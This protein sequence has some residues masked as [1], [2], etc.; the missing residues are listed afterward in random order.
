MAR[1]P[2]CEATLGD[3]TACATEMIGLNW[4]NGHLAYFQMAPRG[5]DWIRL[6][7]S[8]SILLNSFFDLPNSIIHDF[9]LI[10]IFFSTLLQLLLFYRNME[11]SLSIRSKLA[12]HSDTQVSFY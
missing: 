5:F 11:L 2:G 7:Y 8:G 3:L 1:E 6:T 4:I 10:L 9:F 12:E